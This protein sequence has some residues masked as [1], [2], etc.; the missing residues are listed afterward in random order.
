MRSRGLDRQLVSNQAVYV[1]ALT[2]LLLALAFLLA[3]ADRATLALINDIFSLPLA[4]VL[5]LTVWAAGLTVVRHLMLD[6][7]E[8]KGAAGVGGPAAAAAGA[9]PV[10][11][12]AR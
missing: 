2:V 6:A 1:A 9:V 5:P 4:V 3:M 11:V 12:R 10:G 7:A 8:A